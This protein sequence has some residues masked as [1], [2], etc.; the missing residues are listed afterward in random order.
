MKDKRL[1]TIYALSLMCILA[2]IP[3]VTF[4]TVYHTDIGNN[5]WIAGTAFYD[6]FLYYK[7]QLLMLT[8]LIMGIA[9]AVSLLRGYHGNLYGKN[10]YYALIPVGIFAL[11][12]FVS[13]M[14][15]EHRADALFGGYEQFEGLFVILC[16]VFCFVFAYIY[17]TDRKWLD[18]LLYTLLIGSLIL[19]FTGAMQAFHLDYMTNKKMLPFLTMFLKNV[20][21]NFSISASFGEGVSYATLYNPNYVGTYVALVLPVTVALGLWGRKLIFRILAGISALFQII[22]LFGAQSMTGLIGVAGGALVAILFLF[23]DLRKNRRLLFGIGGVALLAIAGVLV[24]KPDLLRQFTQT[25]I[26]SCNYTVSSIETSNDAF[27]ILLDN[28][29][30]IEGRIAQGKGIHECTLYDT[31]GSPLPTAGTLAAGLTIPKE[32]YKG[33]AFFSD[34]KQ[35]SEGDKTINYDILRISAGENYSWELLKR[36]DKLYYINGVG[37]LDTLRKVKSLGFE[38]RYDL[39]TNR[40]YI[41]SRTLPLLQENML[42]GKGADNFVYAFPNDDYVGKINCGF[43]SQTITKPHNMYMQIW[44]QDGMPACLAFLAIFVIFAIRTFR[45]CFK[46]GTLTYAQKIQIA[47]FCGS[48]GYMTAGIANDSTICVAPIFWCL[49]GTGMAVS[50]KNW[51][52]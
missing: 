17:V 42:L 15:S 35:F 43:G 29:K 14:V 48:A 9:T 36:N 28:G 30:R 2:V 11:F 38:H 4:I 8:G 32:E 12:S 25:T 10:S 49:L 51:K 47:V 21:E 26:S 40:G 16:Y 22:M 20:P 27:Q 50:C 37:K 41:W 34:S 39:A 19:S 24:G 6:F 13:A 45:R 46:K 44:V 23:A 1:E 3:L 18:L 33:I 31:A 7:S 5:T 52:E